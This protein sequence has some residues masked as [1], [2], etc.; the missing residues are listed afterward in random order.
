MASTS[1]I[2]RPMK[3]K[4]RQRRW[5]RLIPRSDLVVVGEPRRKHAHE[6]LGIWDGV[7]PDVVTLEGAHESLCHSI[8]LRALERGGSWLQ[9]NAAGE[10]QPVLDVDRHAGL[11]Q[12]SCRQLRLAPDPGPRTT[13]ACGSRSST[14]ASKRS[15]AA[16]QARLSPAVDLPMPPLSEVNATTFMIRCLS[17]RPLR[18]MRP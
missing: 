1:P 3:R 8:A 4:S 11:G 9:T 17:P 6:G 7:H 14:A 16:A 10:A 15:S 12:R 13:E 18:L 2:R 5:K